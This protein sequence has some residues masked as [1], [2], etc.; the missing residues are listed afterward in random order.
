M[1]E[2]IVEY[3][4][5]GF[6]GVAVLGYLISLYVTSK[7][8]KCPDPYETEYDEYFEDKWRQNGED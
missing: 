6:G 2:D 8:E 4:C 5:L 7:C 1:I 3:V